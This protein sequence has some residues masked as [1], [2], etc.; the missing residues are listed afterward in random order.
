MINKHW[1]PRL[2]SQANMFSVYQEV[3]YHMKDCSVLLVTLALLT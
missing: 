2:A 3:Q 1:F